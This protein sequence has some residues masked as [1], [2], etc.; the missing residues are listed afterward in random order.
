MLVQRDGPVDKPTDEDEESTEMRK[1]FATE[2]ADGNILHSTSARSR[3][4]TGQGAE[5]VERM[6]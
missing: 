6:N 5:N 3:E 4:H 2:L 1:Q